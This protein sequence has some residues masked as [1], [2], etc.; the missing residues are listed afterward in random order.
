MTGNTSASSANRK[1]P[2]FNLVYKKLADGTLRLRL[3]VLCG[4]SLGT[5]S[6]RETATTGRRSRKIAYLWGE[7]KNASDR[8]LRVRRE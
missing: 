4:K 2:S 8:E 7:R 6:V 5:E 1:N 3:R